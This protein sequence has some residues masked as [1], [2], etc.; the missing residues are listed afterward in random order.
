MEAI[1]KTAH[2]AGLYLAA[3]GKWSFLAALIGGL[4]GVIGTAFHVS[5]DVVTEF[6]LTHPWVLWALPVLGL[7]IVGLYK[8]LR[9]EGKGTN[10]VL[11]SVQNGEPLPLALTPA[12][13]LSTVLTHLGGGS[14][15]REG[16]ALQMGGSLGYT[17]GKWL[18][19]SEEER[20]VAVLMGMAAFFTALFGTPLAATIFV[21]GVVS[22]GVFCHAAL[23]PCLLASLT[24]MGVSGLLGVAPT[25]FQVVAPALDAIMLLRVAGLAALCALVSMLFC[26]GVHQAEHLLGKDVKNPWLRVALGGG[27]LI[28]LT[29]LMGNMDYNGAGM[30]VIA[31]A[32]EQGRAVPWAFALKIIFTALSLGAGFK[33]GE[34]VPSFFVGAT[35]GCVAGPLLGIPAGF[36]AAVGLAAVFCGATNSPVASLLLAVEMFGGDGL[37]YYA[38]ACALSNLLSGY[39][40]LYSAQRVRYD[41]LRMRRIDAHTNGYAEK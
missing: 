21:I 12:I 18:R 6:R 33:G 30:G 39:A 3:L 29:L 34:V 19:L 13:F 32:I 4:C 26:F 20:R 38:L 35:F 11:L 25:R 17:A 8:L 27:A 5:V 23:L 10:H 22:L 36:A 9:V 24:A 41:K 31:A 15:G 28:A 7:A 14:V 37:L 2:R 16:A 1:K 40:G